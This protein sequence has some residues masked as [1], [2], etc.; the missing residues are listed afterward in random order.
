MVLQDFDRCKCV[1]AR[2]YD[3][4]IR[5]TFNMTLE[6][7]ERKGLIIHNEASGFIHAGKGST[8]SVTLGTA[9]DTGVD[10]DELSNRSNFTMY[11][12]SSS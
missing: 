6:Y 4:E 5:D 3:L 2:P 7:F 11:T 1:Y 9:L 8:G 12:S 10:A